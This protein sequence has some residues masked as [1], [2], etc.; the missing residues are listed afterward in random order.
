MSSQFNCNQCIT[1]SK[2][3]LRKDH[4][5]FKLCQLPVTILSLAAVDVNNATYATVRKPSILF[6]TSIVNHEYGLISDH[7]V[8]KGILLLSVKP[9]MLEGGHIMLSSINVEQC[10]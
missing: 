7:H 5:E 10:A 4:Y 2:I 1:F 6:M 8:Q 9:V 3:N